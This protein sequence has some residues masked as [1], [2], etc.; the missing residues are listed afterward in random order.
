MIQQLTMLQ[1]QL[2]SGDMSTDY[3]RSA[4]LSRA[5]TPD[6]NILAQA[7]SGAQLPGPAVPSTPSGQPA[8]AQLP[9]PAAPSTASPDAAQLPGPA[10]PSTASPDQSAQLPG[11]TVPSTPSPVDV[12]MQDATKP[13][14]PDQKYI[15]QAVRMANMSEQEIQDHVF[16]LSYIF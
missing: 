8:A 3:A 14:N 11:P 2:S 15:D 13:E 4:L 16:T 12:K 10:A 9:G 5:N 7:M 1:K 6:F